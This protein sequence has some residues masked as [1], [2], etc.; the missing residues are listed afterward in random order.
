M[1]LVYARVARQAQRRPEVGGVHVLAPVPAGRDRH[2]AAHDQMREPVPE[3]ALLAARSLGLTSGPVHL[4]YT[5]LAV[6][7]GLTSY[8]GGVYYGLYAD[9]NRLPHP[10]TEGVGEVAKHRREQR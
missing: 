2:G 9:R 5:D 6:S 3:A 4:L 8:D 7:I 1:I 10:P